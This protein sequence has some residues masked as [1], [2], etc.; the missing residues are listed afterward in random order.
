[1]NYLVVGE[2]CVDL[3]HKAD[4]GVIHSYGGI[5]YSIIT[6]SVLAKKEDIVIP[7]MN[8]G[9]DEYDNITDI[10]KKYTN[11]S[12]DGI[13]KVSH[14]TRKVNLYY[15]QYKS[16]KS[17]RLEQSTEPTY[18][19]DYSSIEKF[20]PA[21]DAMLVNMISGVDITLETLKE[22]RNNF[23]GIMHIDI[24]N[25]VMK[26]NEDG[27]REHTSVDNWIEWC[28]N[29]DT[30]QMN[31]Y[32]IFSLS[33]KKMKEY[34]IAEEML[35]H[36]R[37]KVRGVIVTRGING[38]SGYIKR[39]KSFGKEKFIDLDKRDINAIEN[40][41][42]VDS[43]GC[44]DVFAASFILDF[45]LNNDFVKSLHYANRIASYNTSLEGIHE[46]YKLR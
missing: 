34:E 13:Y 10:L 7:L 29:T 31:E 45:S 9:E 40:P 8:L 42:F 44:G 2:P 27:T 11:I 38:S 14:P 26:T 6:L 21:A 43:T 46:L 33:A 39:E 5:L 30:I 1:M 32:E 20:L 3:I 41:H 25:L 36:P 17:A 22:I 18:T 24:H 15:N 4:G 19:L 23:E 35:F 37:S 28:I 16:G 12:L